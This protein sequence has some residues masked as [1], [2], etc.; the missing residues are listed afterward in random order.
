MGFDKATVV[1]RGET[2]AARGARVLQSVCHA[3]VEVGPGVSVLPAVCEE[4]AGA[5]PLAA[6]VAGADA[7][8]TEAIL[9]LACDLPFVD[10]ALLRLIADWPGHGTVVPIAAGQP[11][12]VCARYGGASLAIAR[13]RVGSGDQAALAACLDVA[14]T[15]FIAEDVWRMVAPEHAF[16]DLDTPDDFARLG[17]APG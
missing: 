17:L 2:L 13:A 7:V 11:Q 15:E 14:A 4:P 6:L 12:Y 10:E 8:E 9:L 16:D 1:V 3:S 5:G